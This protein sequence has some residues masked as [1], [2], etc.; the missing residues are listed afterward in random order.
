[1]EKRHKWTEQEDKVLIQLY[2]CKVKTAKIA[3]VL[4][5]PLGKVRSRIRY[6]LRKGVIVRNSFIWTKELEKE[7]ANTL[8]KNAGN[9]KKGMKEFAAKHNIN[10]EA[11]KS[12]YYDVSLKKGR[13]KDKYPIFTMF[14]RYR[15]ATNSK[16]YNTKEAKVHNFWKV[17]K[18]AFFK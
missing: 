8:S 7:L 13:L 5:L 12:R 15:G 11:V 17:V 6:F 4:Q 1:M 10:Y 9:L 14:G 18:K 3:A 16:V 2:S